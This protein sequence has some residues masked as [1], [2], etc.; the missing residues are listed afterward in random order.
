MAGLWGAAVTYTVIA[1]GLFAIRFYVT[2]Q[3]LCSAPPIN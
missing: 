2:R 3:Q 1:G